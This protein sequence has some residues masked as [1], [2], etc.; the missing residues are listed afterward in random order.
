VPIDFGFR[1]GG[2]DMFRPRRLF[3]TFSIKE[4][5]VLLVLATSMSWPALAQDMPKEL[6][7]GYQAVPNP[8]TIVKDLGWHEK[9]IGI[10]IKWMPFDSGKHVVKAFA[11]GSID[12]GL[13]GTSPCAAGIANGVPMEVIYIHDIIGDAESLVVKKSSAIGQIEDL[14]GKTVATPFGST[15]HY[16]L[17]L[18]LNLYRVKPDE[19]D[20][21][22]L[23]PGEMLEAWQKGHLDGAFVWEPT[24]SKLIQEDGQI[25]LFSRQLAERGF[26]T[27]DL[28]VVRPEF[29]TRYPAVVVKYLKNLDRAVRLYRSE[30]EKAASAVARQLG[31]SAEQASTQMKGLI[32]LTGE[33]QLSGKYVGNMDLTFGLYTLLKDTADFLERVN[34]IETSPPWPIFMRAVTASFVKETIPA[35]KA[36]IVG[37][38]PVTE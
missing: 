28:C 34:E 37:P 35:K 29:A 14:A 24:L 26:P 20:I 13:V 1:K 6:I 10:P 2:E 17:I 4:I 8:E 5:M 33:E 27:A 16:H 30:P 36:T 21:I 3:S 22:D 11:A 9:E 25:I 23:E 7:I 31:I 12:I 18:A 38:R 19:L 32:F 15:T